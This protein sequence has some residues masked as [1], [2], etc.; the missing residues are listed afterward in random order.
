MSQYLPQK[1]EK[2]EIE[3]TKSAPTYL[4]PVDIYEKDK[5]LLVVADLPG[6]DEKTVDVDFEK[7]VLIIKGSVEE[8]KNEGYNCLYKEYDQG[9]F[10][11]KFTVPEKIDIEKIEANIKNGIL[12][13]KLPYVPEKGP[14][15]VEVKVG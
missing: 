1:D 3:K 14:K 7:G 4:P 8:K 9:N 13:L 11:R 6:V 2:Q 12:K 15:K 5:C 10:E